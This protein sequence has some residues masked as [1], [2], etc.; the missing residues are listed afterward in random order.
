[1]TDSEEY[2][3]ADDDAV[4]TFENRESSE[5]SDEEPTGMPSRQ[6]PRN[7]ARVVHQEPVTQLDLFKMLFSIALDGKPF[8]DWQT[9][10]FENAKEIFNLA[11][12]PPGCGKTDIAIY[13]S[14]SKIFKAYV[15]GKNDVRLSLT[16]NIVLLAVPYRALA[17]NIAETFKKALALCHLEQLENVSKRLTPSK[18]VKI[19][20]GPGAS[21]DIKRAQVVIATYEHATNLLKVEAIQSRVKFV[22]VD[23]IHELFG[24]RGP[25]VDRVL[26]RSLKIAEA[27]NTPEVEEDQRLTIWGL[28]G[29]LEDSEKEALLRC[30]KKLLPGCPIYSQHATKVNT[31]RKVYW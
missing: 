18:F 12:I 3:W 6:R 17:N 20:E 29:S 2:I 24:T 22:V 30:Y 4:D 26:C 7:S 25:T 13:W 14:I 5:L 1:M 19:V 9:E 10:W 21:Y 28:T 16:P 31:F 23:E 15:D 8:Y 27:L 11:V